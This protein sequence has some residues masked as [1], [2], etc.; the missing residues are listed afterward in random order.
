MWKRLLTSLFVSVLLAAFGTTSIHAY[1]TS[2]NAPGGGSNTSSATD[3]TVD[4]DPNTNEMNIKL[5]VVDNADVYVYYATEKKIDSAQDVIET[6]DYGETN[7]YIGTCSGS[8]CTP[9]D[10]LR[11][12]VKVVPDGETDAIIKW[13][14]ID[15]DGNETIVNEYSGGVN[16]TDE[17]YQWLAGVLVSDPSPTPTPT[18]TPSSSSSGDSSGG[19]GSSS[20]SSGSTGPASPYSCAAATPTD[21]TNLKIVSQ[22][23]DSITLAWDQ[24]S[25]VT[26]YAL[27]FTRLSDG[28]K[29][30]STNIGNVTN[31]EINGISGQSAYSF[32]VFAVNDCMPGSIAT[33]QTE[34]FSGPVLTS[35]PVATTGQVLGATD[36]VNT[37]L[38]VVEAVKAE[39]INPSP[40][41]T[42]ETTSGEVLGDETTCSAG[43]NWWFWFVL[44]LEIITLVIIEKLMVS[45]EDKIIWIFT[46]VAVLSSIVIFELLKNMCSCDGS[47]LC[48][49]FYLIAILLGVA[50]RLAVSNF[51]K[52]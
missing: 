26:H 23:S 17:E 41:P 50:S 24:A 25:P 44:G 31:Y 16:L 39:R 2:G 34:V 3:F 45:K 7:I 32:E 33:V 5:D 49:Y 6:G 40:T 12:V 36:E 35:R 4:F 10:I 47:F 38:A 15:G 1:F 22:G 42:P 43:F 13:V 28:E 9:D 20:S 51:F 29:Y 18:P 19:T 14:E 48:Q 37:E 11:A 27:I 30:G 8:D 46:V 52:K 21:L